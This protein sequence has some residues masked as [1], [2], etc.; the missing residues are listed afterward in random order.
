MLGEEIQMPDRFME[1]LSRNEVENRP[2]ERPAFGLNIL[3]TYSR[4]VTTT[5]IYEI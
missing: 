5:R 3:M 1:G 2:T 4:I